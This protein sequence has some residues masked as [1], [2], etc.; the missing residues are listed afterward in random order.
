[1]SRQKIRKYFDVGPAAIAS[2]SVYT[3]GA[4]GWASGIADSNN[5]LV[6]STS[7]ITGLSQS[8]DDQGRVG[9]SINVETLDVRVKV[10]PDNTLAGH[11]HLR[12]IIF[13]DE[14]CD[15]ALASVGELLG[16]TSTTVANGLVMSFLQ[17][18]YFGRF[19][20][21]EDKHLQ[22]YNSSTA[23]SFEL[24]E[25]P[26]GMWHEAHH[27]LKGHRVMWDA[28]NSSAIAN[29]RKGHIFIVFLYE[30]STVATGG[31]ITSN[32]TNPPG[33]QLTTRIRYT[34]TVDA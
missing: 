27:D 8:D 14:E 26:H 22:W 13:S 10:L 7:W 5:A 24:N 4:T 30:N 2:T 19:K 29:A 20:I 11:G 18:G 3:G 25:G 16:A 17:P 33:I 21:I 28:S 12:M 1:M 32:T 23:N 9:Q 15:G 34:D 31:V 6:L